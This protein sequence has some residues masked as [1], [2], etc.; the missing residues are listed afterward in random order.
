MLPFIGTQFLFEMQIIGNWNRLIHFWMICTLFSSSSIKNRMA[1]SLPKAQGFKVISFYH[2]LQTSGDS[3]FP[4][5]AIWR[6]PPRVGFLMYV[7][8]KD[9]L[10]RTDNLK[11]R[12]L[13][14]L[15][16]VAHVCRGHNQSLNSTLLYGV[17][18]GVF[19]VWIG[20]SSSP[21]C[22]DGYQF[23]CCVGL[24]FLLRM[25]DWKFGVQFHRVWCGLFGERNSRIL[26]IKIPQYPN[27]I[28]S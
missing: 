1:W 22:L 28:H 2:A 11:R 9:K 4:W 10:L 3:S 12:G 17:S 24:V 18:C 8:L 13:F 15:I 14:F 19:L 25:T 6:A 26:K 27:L 16:G 21:V 23:C 5:R 20:C 7:T